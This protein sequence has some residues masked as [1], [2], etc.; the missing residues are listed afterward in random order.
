MFTSEFNGL[1]KYIIITLFVFLLLVCASLEFTRMYGII[2]IEQFIFHLAFAKTGANFSMVWRL[3]IN[4]IIN[5]LLM[6]ILSLFILSIKIYINGRTVSIPFSKHK[7]AFTFI[8]AILPAAGIIYTAAVIGLPSYLL[9]II[10]K[11]STFFEE[12][13]IPPDNAAITFPERK[14]NL[15]VIVIESLE[16]GFLTV[17][18]GVIKNTGGRRS[19]LT[20]RRV[21]GTEGLKIT[22]KRRR[23]LGDSLEV[24]ALK[25]FIL[26]DSRQI[27][28]CFSP[29]RTPDLFDNLVSFPLS[30]A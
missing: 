30:F 9:G 14:R 5:A 28:A 4:A 13:Y 16:T 20:E 17:E 8:A 18:N 1:P 7:T 15:I 19:S 25:Q 3:F 27:I 10:E 24:L 11:P 23:D 2:P 12:H 21:Q 26:T 22:E 6:L 29:R